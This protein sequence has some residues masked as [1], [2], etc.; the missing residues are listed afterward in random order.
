MDV[1]VIVCTRNRPESLSALLKSLQGLTLPEELRWEVLIMGNNSD[2]ATRKVAEHY[3]DA[4]PRRFTFIFEKGRGKSYAL[5]TGVRRS[6]GR[7]IAF[8]DDDC[9]VDPHWISSIMTE[10]AADPDLAVLSGRVELYDKTDRAMTVS[11]YKERAAFSPKRLFFDPLVIGANV[12]F[13]KEVFETVGMYDVALSPGSK[14]QAEAEDADMAYRAYRKGFK[15]VYSPIP[16]VYHNHGRKTVRAT[17]G[18][19]RN[20]WVGRGSFYCKHVLRGDLTV[21]RLAYWDVSSIVR[22]MGE[23]MRE[24][25][26][27]RYQRRMLQGILRGALSRMGYI[28]GRV[29]GVGL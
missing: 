17:E 4:D 22:A 27:T 13:K 20:Y 7:V 9:I 24:R 15:I 19:E 10:Y 1:S 28:A 16:L 21:A 14:S 25:Q 11:P 23:R 8:T 3:V 29:L 5:N 2:D 12:A 26:S 18:L 6:R